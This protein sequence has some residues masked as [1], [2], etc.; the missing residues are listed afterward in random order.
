MF[1]FIKGLFAPK[2]HGHPEAVIIS[3]FF[4]PQNSPYR[5]KAFNLWYDSIKHLNHRVVECV[6]GDTK[7]QLKESRYIKRVYTQTLL[8]HKEAILN[9][10]ISELPDKYKYVFW[11][12]ADVLF[13]NLEWLVDGVKELQTKNII[14]PFDYCVHLEKDEFQPWSTTRKM[15]FYRRTQNPNQYNKKVWRSFCANCND[16]EYFNST[17]YNT[18]GHVGFAWGARR[19]ILRAMPLYDKALVGGAD[20]IIAHAAAGQIGHPCITKSFKDN[21]PEIDEWS[22]RF[23]DLVA[24]KIGYV[25]SDLYHIW[26]GD[27]DKRQYLQRILDFTERSKK[28]N[29]RDGNG[30]YV[31]S[32]EEEAYLKKYFSEREVYNPDDSF[33]RSMA[34]GYLTDSSLIGTVVGGNPTGALIGDMLNTSDEQNKNSAFDDNKDWSVSGSGGDWDHGAAVNKPEHETLN[35]DSTANLDNLQPFS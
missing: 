30:L 19:E 16:P 7:P 15:E 13:S 18:H 9:M 10:I 22:R 28:I 29:Q 23:S 17:N 5:L 2:Y 4:N 1:K 26:H 27:I 6:I 33:F 12:D 3:C 31:A 35:T 20:H 21:L 32:K 14:Q 11:I 24:G 8:W 34:I 25:Q